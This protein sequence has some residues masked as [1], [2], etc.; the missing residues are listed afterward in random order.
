MVL[1]FVSWPLEKWIHRRHSP[2]D[3]GNRSGEGKGKFAGQIGG[4]ALRVIVVTGGSN[5][6]K[7]L[8]TLVSLPGVVSL[9]EPVA[10]LL[11]IETD[12]ASDMDGW[13]TLLAEV[14]NL[15]LRAPKV[16][17]NIWGGPEV[18]FGNG[19]CIAEVT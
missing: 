13:K 15:A 14:E 12:H 16:F 3:G 4:G 6:R 9:G 5:I 2:T 18:V 10:H 8:G 1:L 17:G 11:L 19:E 7:I